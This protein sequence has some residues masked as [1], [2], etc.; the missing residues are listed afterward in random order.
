MN[1]ANGHTKN[2]TGITTGTQSSKQFNPSA[3]SFKNSPKASLGETRGGGK[4]HTKLKKAELADKNKDDIKKSLANVI[5]VY[6]PQKKTCLDTSMTELT[7][8]TTQKEERMGR[9]DFHFMEVIG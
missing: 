5:K 8:D 9:A 7:K 2:T 3:A 4:E 1:F 6:Y